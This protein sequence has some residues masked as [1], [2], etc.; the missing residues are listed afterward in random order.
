[1]NLLTSSDV[2]RSSLLVTP[3]TTK[4]FDLYSSCRS[5]RC[6][7]A[8]MHG[9]HHVAQNSRTYTFFGSKDLTA[10]P[11]IHFAPVSFGAGSPMPSLGLASF[12]LSSALAADASVFLAGFGSSAATTAAPMINIKAER[13]IRIVSLIR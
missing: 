2:F 5:E 10:S 4:P 9:G 7:I 8:A 11:L 12:S 1:M 6:G 3:T 13:L